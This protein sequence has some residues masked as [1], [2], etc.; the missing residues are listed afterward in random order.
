MQWAIFQTKFLIH[1]E[2]STQKEESEDKFDL[3][4]IEQDQ[5]LEQM[6]PKINKGA[7]K[8]FDVYKIHEL[9]EPDVLNSLDDDAVKLLK[10][11]MKDLPLVFE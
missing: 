2:I 1:T 11:P 3:S 10:T 9:I 4:K 6:V 7:T 8:L 5:Q